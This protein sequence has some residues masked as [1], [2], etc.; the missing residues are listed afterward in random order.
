MSD[1]RVAPRA[2]RFGEVA[3]RFERARPLYPEPALSEPAAR[4]RLRPGTR[5]GDLGAGRDRLG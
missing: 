3:E 5:V 4:C 1:P 2:A